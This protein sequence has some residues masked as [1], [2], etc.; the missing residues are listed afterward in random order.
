MKIGPFELLDTGQTVDMDTVRSL[1]QHFSQR[2]REPGIRVNGRAVVA[3]AVFEHGTPP[4]MT[5][6]LAG[7]A[8]Y[9]VTAVEITKPE[10][11]R[12]AEE[13]SMRGVEGARDEP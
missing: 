1:M 3:T 13:E 8:K 9:V 12:I 2:L 6:M 4:W 11:Q 10:M 5:V 7:G